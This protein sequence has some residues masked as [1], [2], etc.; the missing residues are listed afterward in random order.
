MAL[1]TRSNG[2]ISTNLIQAAWFNDFKDLLTGVM[3]DQEV[4]IKNNLVLTTIGSG[5][6][7]APT[8]A[9]ATGAG[10]GIGVYK[11]EV[12]FTSPDGE[13]LPSTSATVTT[14]TGNQ[15]VNVTAIPTGPTGTTG[16]KIYRTAVGGLSFL[17][18]NTIA[19]N[20]TTSFTDTL[21]DGS[22]GAAPPTHPSFGGSLAIKNLAGIVLARLFNDGSLLA[23]AAKLFSDGNG[24]L[25]LN[26]LLP[27]VTP[28]LMTGTTTGT[29]QLWQPF[30]GPAFKLLII[31]HNNLKNGTSTVQSFTLSTAFANGALWI[32]TGMPGISVMSS[33]VAQT[34]N[35]V[36]SL[37]TG[38]GGS[39]TSTNESNNSFG[40]INHAFDTLQYSASNGTAH[41]GWLVFLGN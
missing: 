20:T 22:L 39:S 24:N 1:T 23:D 21:A 5:P 18:C 13:T 33:G 4:T 25:N 7:S 8:L 14:T 19:D 17:L 3:Q 28:L 38:G 30:S 36:T 2:N 15:Q 41:T 6:G 31:Y 29:A 35:I 12:T 40:D 16:R 11:Y 32:S 27:S 26:T 37:A 9:V 10:L 34:A